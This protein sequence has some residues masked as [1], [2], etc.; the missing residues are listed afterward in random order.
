VARLKAAHFDERMTLVEHLDE[1]RS[2]IIVS[3]VVLGVAIA[4]CF[5]QNHLLLDIANKPLPDSLPEPITFSP[6]EPFMTTLKVSAY[7]GILLA[8]PIL[9]YQA[10]AFVLPA[11]A[12]REKRVILPF[13]LMVP[14]LFIAGV[15]FSYFVVVPAAAQFLLNFN[16]DQF[17]IQI[18]AS[19]YYGFFLLTLI[20]V[21][22]VFQ[23]PVGILALTRL[24]IVT[25]EQLAHNRRYAILIIAVIAML[26]PGT[27]P[28]TMLISMLPLVVLFELSVQ[29]SKVLGRPPKESD[30]ELSGA[31]APAGETG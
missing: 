9:L 8:L 28:V 4:L 2:R 29:L 22:I 26:L 11:L 6:T 19:E 3:L 14:F 5:W 21:G 1:L 18:R 31:D 13:L 25:P 27:D 7:A 16:S 24:G 30:T 15:V 20:S 12:P 23:I 17:N 10:Y